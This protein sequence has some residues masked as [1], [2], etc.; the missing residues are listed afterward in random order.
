LTEIHRQ[1]LPMLQI[2]PTIMMV[3]RMA[4][5]Y[6][7]SIGAYSGPPVLV[8]HLW[9]VAWGATAAKHGNQDSVGASITCN[10][11]GAITDLGS[12]LR[13]H[14]KYGFGAS[15]VVLAQLGGGIYTNATVVGAHLIGLVESRELLLSTC[16]SQCTPTDSPGGSSRSQAFSA[17]HDPVLRLHLRGQSPPRGSARLH[18]R[19]LTFVPPSDS[20][21]FTSS[22]GHY[23]HLIGSDVYFQSNFEISATVASQLEDEL[24]SRG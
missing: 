20:N 9:F 15:F 22:L 1:Q 18:W 10:C 5:A 12:I 24:S 23:Q 4:A 17:M 16:L 8:H 6:P 21:I 11:Y 14:Y 13:W 19:P 7:C 2:V 3:S